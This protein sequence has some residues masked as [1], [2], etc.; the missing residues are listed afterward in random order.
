[1]TPIS[2][3][4]FKSLASV[5][6]TTGCAPQHSI[7]INNVTSPKVLAARIFADHTDPEGWA[8]SQDNLGEAYRLR[9]RGDRADNLEKA[10]EHCQLALKVY[11]RQS[12]AE[13][14]ATAQHNLA[15]AYCYRIRGKRAD[16]LE[17]AF[18]CCQQMLDVR[19][20]QADPEGWAKAQSVLGEIHS[21]LAG[22]YPEGFRRNRVGE[23]LE[24]AIEHTHQALEVY[25]QQAYPEEWA[26]TQHNL[27][28]LYGERI[29]G[30]RAENLERSI[31]Y[32]EKALQVYTQQAY[33]ERWAT[34]QSNLGNAYRG[35]L[36]GK[37]EDNLKIAIEHYQQALGVIT[38]QNLPAAHQQIQ[39][40][41][42]TL[43]FEQMAWAPA[44]EAF[45]AAFSAEEL[46]LASSYTETGR[47][48]EVVQ[49]AAL[50]AKATYALL[51]LGRTEDALVRL[52]QGRTRLLSRALALSEVEM[53]ILH[54]GDQK[55][56]RSLR[57]TIRALEADMRLLPQTRTRDDVA[58]ALEESRA[59]L[60]DM[61][62]RIRQTHPDF[63]PEQLELSEILA[64]I[65]KD[66]VLVAP[67]ITSQGSVVFIVPAGVKSVTPDQVL[68]LDDFKEADLRAL[69]LGSE[70]EP[71]G[72]GW[73][74]AY[75]SAK[76]DAKAWLDTI[77]I[78]GQVLW[79]RLLAQVTARVATFQSKHLLL[80]P[81]GGLG[82]L[83]LNAGWRAAHGNMHY[84]V[85]EYTV[86]YIPS[87][88][89]RR[90][91]DIRLRDVRRKRRTLFAVVNPTEDLPF[92]PAEAGQIA[93]L[94]GDKNA[95]IVPGRKA[96]SAIV[97]K[98]SA[99]AGYL[100]F[101]CHGFYDWGDPMQSGLV[102]AGKDPLTVAQIIGQFNLED[103]RL[104]TLS[105][106]ETGITDIRQSP[107]EYLG[108]PAG[109]LQAGAPGVVSTLW[110]VNDLS[111]M[112][113]MERFYRLHVRRRMNLPDALCEAQC[114]LRDV[115]ARQLA[116]RFAYEEKAA[117]L[118]RGHMPLESASES[119]VRF[120]LQAPANRPFAHPY[121]WAA[122]SFSGA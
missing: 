22:A 48:A 119:F 33:T 31:E 73:L 104:V 15:S 88:Y 109:F 23:H 45:Q 62:G 49:T 37:R 7:A 19:T 59:K 83:P 60:N 24:E 94:F 52:E 36:L 58:E 53:G 66:G 16:N 41:L 115:T 30:D 87:A 116:K 108:L 97:K 110:S 82:I 70:K 67:V 118:G 12:Y 74:D 89:A 47:E 92:A 76:T 42:G 56:L 79:D 68:W 54:T 100:H 44:L 96:T 111:T 80:M 72:I 14:W 13:D 20:R 8:A 57:E 75:L 81:Q 77:Q 106:C 69:L 35:R 114:W 5:S 32:C 43:H 38:L 98:G 107:D 26:A 28:A 117:L 78:T 10:I 86:C 112:L 105:A 120:T 71:R 29:R 9:I 93:A 65:P 113:L 27:A 25:S 18:E 121:Y 1:M 101:A 11:S 102:L 55:S 84:L 63:M 95:T 122:F 64:L 91:S 103:T 51:R 85:D 39:R 61:I 50:Y 6:S 17:K 3:N 99:T 90:V 40:N 46:L 21:A 4:A 34:T 2:I